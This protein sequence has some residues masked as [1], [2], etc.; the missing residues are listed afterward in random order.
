MPPQVNTSP[1]WSFIELVVLMPWTVAIYTLLSSSILQRLSI[2]EQF[3][4]SAHVLMI[5]WANPSNLR[6][7]NPSIPFHDD[8]YPGMTMI[9]PP[10]WAISR[11]D[12]SI[13]GQSK[14]RANSSQD[15]QFLNSTQSRSNSSH[16]DSI[17]EMI[18]L[19]PMMI[20]FTVHLIHRW[21]FKHFAS[22]LHWGPR[23]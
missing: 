14:F 4:Q 19:D 16:D 23:E 3:R 15:D 13:L 2:D 11:Q 7:A 10:W 22:Q 18:H 8:H 5:W 20:H 17:N 12:D 6:W 1:P 9:V 21:C